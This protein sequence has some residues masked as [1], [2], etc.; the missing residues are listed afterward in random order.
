MADERKKK[1]RI[2]A[3]ILQLFISL[4]YGAMLIHTTVILISNRMQGWFVYLVS[5]IPQLVIIIASVILQFI[6][7]IRHRSHTQE[8]SLLPLLFTF[9]ALEATYILPIYQ[10][11]SG[12]TILAPAAVIIIARFA[13]LSTAVIFVFASVQ[14]YG[15]NNTR[16][17]LYLTLSL[18][19]SMFLSIAAPVST[20]NYGTTLFTSS[21]DAYLSTVIALIY[22]VAAITYIVAVIKD[23]AT[24]TPGRAVSY[25]LLMLGN[26]LS[27]GTGLITG[28]LA[29][30]IYI[31]GVAM[32]SVSSRQTF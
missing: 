19:A 23:R 9:I 31:I 11:V 7:Q 6:L 14:F 16:N 25:I 20:D 26:Y 24:H 12:M 1:S 18:L 8:G 17:K 22:L 28:S 21:Y 3:L 10:E 4:V 5:Y 32:L 29:I 30:A 2:L 15:V 27:L 13:M